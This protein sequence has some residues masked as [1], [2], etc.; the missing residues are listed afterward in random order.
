LIL[1]ELA[2]SLSD[3]KALTRRLV[4]L[5]GSLYALFLVDASPADSVQLHAKGAL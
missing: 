5:S 4:L 1:H 3:A 2:L